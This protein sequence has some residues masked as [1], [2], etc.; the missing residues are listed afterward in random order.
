MENTTITPVNTNPQVQS[1]VNSAFG[2]A[3]ASVIMAEIPIASIIA[4]IMGSKALKLVDS[5]NALAAQYGISAGGKCV[6]A[7]ILGKIG[8]IVGIVMTAFW[9]FYIIFM[10][11]YV[12]LMIS[13]M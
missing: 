3:L 13:T 1:L 2:K 6:A 4:I 10:I 12:I 7:R 11:A 8:K 9:P 5:A